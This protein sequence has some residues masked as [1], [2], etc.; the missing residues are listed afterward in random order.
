[1]S[2]WAA[3]SGVSSTTRCTKTPGRWTSSG[4][5]SP[6]STTFSAST[7][8]S[9][10]DIAAGTLKLRAEAWKTQ[11]P[12]RSTTAARTSATSATMDS[13]S[14]M[15]VPWK[16]RTSLGSEASATVPSVL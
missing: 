15:S 1:M 13:S 9:R 2:L 16:L 5:S 3:C 14:T 6:I 8:V 12:A 11:L 4:P 7:I 10:P